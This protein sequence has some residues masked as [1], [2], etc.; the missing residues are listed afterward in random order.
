MDGQLGVE[1]GIRVS[2]SREMQAAII[3]FT[4]RGPGCLGLFGHRFRVSIDD[5]FS[6]KRAV[7]PG[8]AHRTVRIHGYPEFGDP[9]SMLG[10]DPPNGL[11]KESAGFLA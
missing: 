4:P 11:G 10:L 3:Q 2:D 7:C 9:D 6:D 1:S 8:L 5:R